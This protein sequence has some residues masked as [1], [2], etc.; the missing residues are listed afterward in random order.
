M[1]ESQKDMLQGADDQQCAASSISVLT[2][3]EGDLSYSLALA[4]A[5][6]DAIVLT[7]TTLPPADELAAT[8]ERASANIAELQA[9]GATVVHGVDATDISAGVQGSFDHVCFLHPHLGLSDLLG[10]C[11]SE[12]RT[13]LRTE[14]VSP[15]EVE[16]RGDSTHA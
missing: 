15:W 3:G 14:P 11:K 5:F 6:G 12:N 10:A 8:Y 13:N 7:A 16:S 4:R 2:I 9:R 1:A